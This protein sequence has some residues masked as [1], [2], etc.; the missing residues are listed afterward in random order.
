METGR[1]ALALYVSHQD[2][3]TITTNRGPLYAQDLN[4]LVSRNVTC[5]VGTISS[6]GQWTPLAKLN[7]TTAKKKL[8][9]IGSERMQAVIA[10]MLLLVPSRQLSLQKQPPSAYG[11]N[12]EPL[13]RLGQFNTC[14]RMEK[15]KDC[16]E[17]SG[18]LPLDDKDKKIVVECDVCGQEHPTEECPELGLSNSKFIPQISRARL[19][20]PHYLNPVEFPDGGVGILTLEPIPCKTQL[21]PFEAKKTMHE[22]DRDDLFV[23]KILSK[24]GSF[25]SLDASSEAHCNWMALVQAARNEEEQN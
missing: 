15:E 8:C 2:N 21:G 25:I 7:T 14:N 16:V 12:G 18:D 17:M 19:T 13:K 11:S 20:V 4:G 10:R 22:I 5:L 3:T 24:D 9:D 23:L 6:H 1:Y